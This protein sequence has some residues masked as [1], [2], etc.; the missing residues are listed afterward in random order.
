MESLLNCELPPVVKAIPILSSPT[1]PIPGSS[2][3]PNKDN[4]DLDETVEIEEEQNTTVELPA[5]QDVQ[6]VEEEQNV[7]H[8]LKHPVLYYTPDDEETEHTNNTKES[9]CNA[10]EIDDAPPFDNPVYPSNTYGSLTSTI[11]MSPQI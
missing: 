3:Q 8:D 4:E 2:E 6:G 10:E 9:V 1:F 11:G 7:E 5:E